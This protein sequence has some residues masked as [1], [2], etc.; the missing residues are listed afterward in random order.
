[1]VVGGAAALIIW[2]TGNGEDD[3][4]TEN[5]AQQNQT[6]EQTPAPD[7][8]GSP[9]LPVP[10]PDEGDGDAG[11]GSPG[12]DSDSGSGGSA[13]DVAQVSTLGE[14]AAEAINN[15]DANLAR[16]ISCEPENV[17]DSAFE[18]QPGFTAKVAGDPTIE[19]DNAEIPFEITVQGQTQRDTLKAKKLS[20]GW[21]VA[22]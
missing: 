10:D 15:R 11:T 5:Q 22:G 6:T 20:G 13:D 1:M 7:G 4:G 12:G 8:T 2:L 17:D 16:Q 14:Q 3:P 9:Q 18:G 19:G 21:C